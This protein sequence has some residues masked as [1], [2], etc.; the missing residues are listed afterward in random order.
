MDNK[1]KRMITM[2]G[3]STLI[4][5]IVQIIISQ[6]RQ[7]GMYEVQNLFAIVLVMTGILLLLCKGTKTLIIY[8]I[9]VLQLFVMIGIDIGVY[10]KGIMWGRGEGITMQWPTIWIVVLIVC[11]FIQLYI[12]KPKK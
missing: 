12:A 9:I 7:P 10:Q 2:Y 5:T 8:G 1:D 6:K 11:G 3:I 4:V